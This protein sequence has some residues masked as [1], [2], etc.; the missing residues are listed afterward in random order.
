MNSYPGHSVMNMDVESGNLLPKVSAG[1][2]VQYVNLT[3]GTIDIATS[4]DR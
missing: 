1:I 4:V 3:A 2:A